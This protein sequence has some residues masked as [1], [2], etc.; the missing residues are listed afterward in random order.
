MPRYRSGRVSGVVYDRW[1][2]IT[3]VCTLWKGSLESDGVG[4]A[5]GRSAAEIVS[6]F[7]DILF[8]MYIILFCN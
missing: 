6:F 2:T 4:M 5:S 3:K 8:V 7:V 1:K